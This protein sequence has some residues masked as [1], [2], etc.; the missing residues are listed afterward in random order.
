MT[1]T[2]IAAIHNASKRYGGVQA[3]AHVS[4]SIARG[5]V[6]ALLGKNGAGKSTVIRLLSGVEA[7][8][9]GTVTL[10]GK[11]LERPN[12][13]LAQQLGVRTVYQELSL[14]PYMTVAENL[15]MGVWPK[16]RGQIDRRAMVAESEAS[17]NRL[18]L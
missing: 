2:P 13:Q 9:E 18:G 7:P 11:L 8:D 14:I 10:G 6:R 12:V 1:E 16:R 5:E 15:F 3:L 17:L 4:L